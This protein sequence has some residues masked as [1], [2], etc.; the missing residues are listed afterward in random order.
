VGKG[1]E[2]EVGGSN[3]L[4]SI[5]HAHA[6]NCIGNSTSLANKEILE[7]GLRLGLGD[8]EGLESPPSYIF[9]QV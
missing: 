9:A 3:P 8:Q 1:G 5:L 7:G 2:G 6:K 4:A